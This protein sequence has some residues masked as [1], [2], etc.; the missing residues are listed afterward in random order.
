MLKQIKMTKASLLSLNDDQ[1][2]TTTRLTI[3]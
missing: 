1:L 2:Q 3:L